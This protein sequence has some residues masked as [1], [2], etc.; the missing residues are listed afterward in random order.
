VDERDA[1]I[2]E[3]ADGADLNPFERTKKVRRFAHEVID[4]ERRRVTREIEALRAS[5]EALGDATYNEAID[6]VL[7]VVGRGVPE[8]E[9]D[10]SNDCKAST[11]TEGCFASV[12][13]QEEAS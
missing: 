10:G 6:R 12:P 2:E 4:A 8:Q 9:C 11:H 7:G 13:E 5:G 1:I 3:A